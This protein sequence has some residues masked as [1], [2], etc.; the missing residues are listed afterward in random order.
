MAHNIKVNQEFR[1]NALSLK[2]GGSTVTVMY[3]NNIELEYNNIK[4]PQ[5]YINTI[6][7]TDKSIIGIKINGQLVK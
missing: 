7:K 6:T 3:D 1:K 4:N 5:A 2:P